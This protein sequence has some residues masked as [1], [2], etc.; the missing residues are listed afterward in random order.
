LKYI[1]YEYN[2]IK[3]NVNIIKMIKFIILGFT[4][5]GLIHLLSTILDLII[6]NNRRSKIEDFIYVI[7][8]TTITLFIGISIKK[9]VIF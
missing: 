1:L 2:D 5:F 9:I 3:Y 7:I 4:I 6:C 8:V